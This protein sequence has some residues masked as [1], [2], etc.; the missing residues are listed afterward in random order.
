MSLRDVWKNWRNFWFAPES[1]LA[2]AVFRILF[3]LIM[4][5]YCALFAPDLF[6]WLGPHAICS[7]ETARTALSGFGP[8]GLNLWSFVPYTDTTVAIF[9]A[10]LALS[11]AFLTVGLFS[12]IAAIVVYLM[13]ASL[14][15]ENSLIINGGD[16]LLK[17]SAF[18]LIF[19]P[20]GDTLSLDCR[21]KPQAQTKNE[22]P[23]PSGWIQRLFRFTIALIYFQSFWSKLEEPMW[24]NGSALWYVLREVEYARFPVSFISSNIWMCQ[25]VSWLTLIT[26]GAAWSLIWFKETRYPVIIGLMG[27]HLAIDYCM[28]LPLFEWIM[29]ATLILFVP[30]EDLLVIARKIK[31]YAMKSLLVP[32]EKTVANAADAQ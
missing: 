22:R 21:R 32:A 1:P 19:S 28:N 15:Q 6:N 2:I 14:Q 18:F 27:M 16:I 10:L 17:M 9:L 30:A 26:E 5:V 11:A 8:P 7:R 29:I 20:C 12:R 4:L 13:L 24:L 31:E 25:T 3:G 23:Y